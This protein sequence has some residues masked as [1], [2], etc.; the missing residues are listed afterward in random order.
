MPIRYTRSDRLKRAVI[1]IT[2]P[3][4][5]REVMA[6]VEERHRAEGAWS[7]GL[8]Y[9][10]RHMTGEPDL[11]TLKEFATRTVPKPGEPPRGRVAILADD[12]AIYSRA[13]TYAV[14]AKAHAA[15]AVFRHEDEAER[16]LSEGP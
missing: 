4:D 8:L 5:S 14:L 9:D 3:F 10:L 16:W 1:T 11:A 6:C 2:G 13:C 15:I 12:P 7:Y